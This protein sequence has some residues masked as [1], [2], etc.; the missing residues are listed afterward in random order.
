MIRRTLAALLSLKRFALADEYERAIN[1]PAEELE[2]LRVDKLNRLLRHYATY[3]FYR[4]YAGIKED[5]HLK[6]TVEITALP[7]VDKVFLRRYEAEIKERCPRA[8]RHST[9]GSTGQNFYFYIDRSARDARNAYNI[10]WNRMVGLKYGDRI[11]GIWGGNLRKL[12]DNVVSSKLKSW[13]LN[14]QILPGYGMD[15]AVAQR[16][17]GIIN[18][19]QP[20]MLY[21]YPSYL[22]KLATEGLAAKLEISC[23]P[24]VI[25]SGEQLL[26][27]QRENIEAFFGERV[28]NRYG[29]VEFGNIAYELPGRKGLYINPFQFVVETNERNEILLTD[30]DNYATPFIRYNI[31]DM[32]RLRQ[33]GN[34]YIIDELMGRSNDIIQT[35]SGKMIPSQFWTILSKRLESILE[36][37]VVQ[38]N[39]NEVQM[40]VIDSDQGADYNDII[41]NFN[42]NFGDEMRLTVKKVSKL[43]LTGYG[44]LKFVIKLTENERKKQTNA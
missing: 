38:I 33:D 40:R 42:H 3:P 21:G 26:P 5:I 28:Y 41:S 23:K 1:G 19:E 31:G 13:L 17:I 9:S 6:S 27:K 24:I 35:P 10:F 30:L 32:G 18:K 16:Y 14:Q 12:E 20:R 2:R 25:S 36:F 15:T 37:Q 7:S 34:W 8:E 11:I 4:E 39:D 29:S 43:E 22:N 44:K